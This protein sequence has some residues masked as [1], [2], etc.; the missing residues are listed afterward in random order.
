MCIRDSINAEYG[1]TETKVMCF[2]EADELKARGSQELKRGNLEAALEY[3]DRSI[4]LYGG[5]VESAAA[6][7]NRSLCCL[8]AGAATRAVQ[9]AERA[10][11]ANKRWCKPHYRRAAAHLRLGEWRMAASAA[12]SALD[13]ARTESER[14]EVH[15]L[16]EQ[17][18]S[19]RGKP[20]GEQQHLHSP[21][22]KG[23][24]AGYPAICFDQRVEVRAVEGAG[25]GIIALEAIPANTAVI[26]VPHTELLNMQQVLEA[27]PELEEVV[28]SRLSRV[29][30]AAWFAFQQPSSKWNR[31]MRA[32][33]AELTLPLFFSEW[34]KQQLQ[35]G[36]FEDEVDWKHLKPLQ[37]EYQ[38]L[39]D[40]LRSDKNGS[41]TLLQQLS[42]EGFK[43]VFGLHLSRS[44]PCFL[45]GGADGGAAVTSFV[46]GMDCA[47]TGVSQE[48][49]GRSCELT[50]AE[51]RMEL[52]TTQP[53]QPGEQLLLNYNNRPNKYWLLNFG[54]VPS[55][56]PEELVTVEL[57]SRFEGDSARHE[58]LRA[59]TD[60]AYLALELGFGFRLD[61]LEEPVKQWL[62]VCSLKADQLGCDMASVSRE[63]PWDQ[64]DGRMR[65]VLAAV[66]L[67]KLE[68]F[69]TTPDQDEE[70]VRSVEVGSNLYWAIVY[71][72]ERKR[73]LLEAV[74]ASSPSLTPLP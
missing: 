23:T 13:L 32:C 28:Q 48:E 44:L 52:T 16:Q 69:A 65:G 3:Y 27:H 70:L 6:W 45:D 25:S 55:G 9:D 14:R 66:C 54:F 62:W 41:L 37:D 18:A 51:N 58:L 10:M 19:S 38:Q 50:H 21:D 17:I 26:T 74:N 67:E 46:P 49:R 60:E 42:W 29:L 68:E 31:F 35:D 34:E 57:E 15:K 11:L 64:L 7:S 72:L 59:L 73:I 8:N 5:A 71:R 12:G 36:V 33:P 63:R 1:G 39:L 61:Q 2:S 30:V 4:E 40:L 47:N 20:H 53:C 43:W 56:N 22:P 24:A